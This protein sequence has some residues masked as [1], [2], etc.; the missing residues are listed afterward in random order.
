MSV[1]RDRHVVVMG[2]AGGLGPTVVAAAAAAGARLTLVGSTIEH[3]QPLRAVHRDHVAD[4]VAVDLTDSAAVDRL[5]AHLTAAGGVDVV[6]HLVGGWRGGSPLPDA[7]LADWDWLYQRLVATTVNV[8]RAFAHSLSASPHGRFALVSSP[9]AAAPTTTNAAYAATKA[10]AEATT[11]ALADHFGSVGSAAT[12][13]VVVVPAILTDA[14]RAAQPDRVWTN[15]VPADDLA[16]TL[17]FL[18]GDAAA[19]MNGQRIRLY[20]GSS[21]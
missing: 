15:Q 13:N 16:D 5:A 2:A 21:S 11:L 8:T 19:K 17:V 3:L 4:A 1:L 20:A 6:W 7:P 12:A 14:M 9:Q 10:A 18:A